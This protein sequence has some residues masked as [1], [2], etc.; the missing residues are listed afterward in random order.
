VDSV[1][2][3]LPVHQIFDGLVAHDS[4]LHTVPSLASTWTITDQR[5]YVFHLR[6]GVL[7]HDGAP[8]SSEDVAYTI[9]RLLAPGRARQSLAAP[10]LAVIEGA[11]D[12]SKGRRGDLPGV[13]TPDPLTVRIRLERPYPSF[14]EVLAM[15]SLR[16]VPRHV[17]ERIGEEEFA[18]RPV[19]T[20]PFRLARWGPTDLRLEANPG[21]FLGPPYLDGIEIQF[22]GPEEPEG[23]I[24]R[25][26]EGR[27][28]VVEAPSGHLEK[29]ASIPGTRILRYSELSLNFLGLDTGFPYLE[30]PAVRRAIAHAVDRERIASLDPAMRRLATGILPP[31]LPG[32]SPK[33][34]T[35]PY[36]PD[37]ARA[38]LAEAGHPGGAG[39]P[40][41]LLYTANKG[42]AAKKLLEAV[43]ADLAA[44]GIR[45]EVR[46]VSWA[47]FSQR[48]EDHAAPAFLLGWIADLTDPDTFLRSLF[49]P[50]AS[51]NYFAFRDP[52]VSSLLDRGA[53]ELH[54]VERAKIY[55]ALEERIVAEAPIIPLYHNLRALAVRRAVRDLEPTPLGLSAVDFRKVWLDEGAVP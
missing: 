21:Y 15:D 55:R 18:R 30:K 11:A 3:A 28:D 8:L 39:L 22:P 27:A 43:R 4:S 41:L 7:F 24:E 54:P 34:K 13:D 9:R 19:G 12:F 20:G 26:Y 36:D 44:V 49:E 42:T 50:G 6:P 37:R 47:E 48:L 5:E 52:E 38:L 31:G 25:F 17:V 10:Y 46:T 1:Y 29:L 40:P 16:V 33:P 53:K 2:D 23:G 32:Y 45:L 51:A 35:L 14:L